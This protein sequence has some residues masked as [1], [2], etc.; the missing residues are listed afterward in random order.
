ME[1]QSLIGVLVG[2][3][4]AVFGGVSFFR[5]KRQDDA[6]GGKRDGVVLTELG[7]IKSGVDDIKRRQER[8]DERHVEVVSRLTAVE[9]SARQAHRRLDQAE[10]RGRSGS[11]APAEFCGAK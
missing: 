1:P 2:I 7:Y 8:Q 6:A 9:A 5:N 11:C 10:A 4:G 3:A